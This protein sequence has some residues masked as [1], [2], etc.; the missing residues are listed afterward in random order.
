M[1]ESDGIEEAFE[2]GL[3]VAVTAA[4]QLGEQLAR[5]RERQLAQSRAV[6]EE[7][8]RDY[9]RRL[10]AE[11]DTARAEL[12]PVHREEW[13]AGADAAAIGKAYTTAHAWEYQDADAF[14]A[15]SKIRTEVRDRYG[16]DVD[17]AGAD[18]AAVAAAISSS[19]ELRSRADAERREGR[20]DAAEA[21]VLVAA[22]DRA[23][24]AAEQARAAAE[25]E[26]DPVERAELVERAETQT[27]TAD[28]AR[29]DGQL[30]YDSAERRQA[31]AAELDAKGIDQA[32]IATRMRADISQAKP[33]TEATRPSSV[34]SAAGGRSHAGQAKTVRRSR[35]AG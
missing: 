5:M 34:K 24:H 8:G 17:N 26:P 31:F 22:A 4:A 7:Q 19:E 32:H 12:A 1:S 14:R 13:W 10:H 29:A 35:S 20:E 15:A 9:A 33:A 16:V 6:S 30:A 28:P 25:H 23:D 2:G 21:Q 11:R 18:L 3:R 27:T